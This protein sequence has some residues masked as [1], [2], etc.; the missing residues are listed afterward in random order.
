MQSAEAVLEV[1]RER[2]RRGLP[3][4]RVYRQ[5][6]NRD[7]YLRAYGRLARN[8]GAL[9]PGPTAETA[10]G[11]SVAKIDA[12]IEAV[13]FERYRWTPVRRTYLPKPNGKRR[14]LGIPTW[15]DKLLQEV[16]RSLLE[17]YY[18][19]QF[20]DHSHGFRPGRG[21]HTALTEVYRGWKGTTWFIEGDIAQCFDSLDHE[22]LLALLRERLHDHRFLR[23]VAGS[24]TAGYLEDWAFHATLSGAPQG[25]VVSPVLSNIYL[26]R[27]DRFVETTLLPAYNRG[28]RRRANPAYTQLNN[29]ASKARRNGDQ[30]AARELRR[31]MQRLPSVAA[32]DPAYR[33]LRY[34][35]YADDW[36]LGFVGPRREAEAI[37]T[38][39]R[40]FLSAT[41]KLQLS[42]A[43]TVITHARSHA[44]RFLGYEATV[45]HDDRKHDQTGGR[46]INGV[47]GLKVP[48]DVVRRNAAGYLRHGKPI[49]RTERVND[50]A[51][52][53]VARYQQEFRG[54]VE[55]YRLA[56]NLHRF[57]R[58]AWDM[59]RSLTKTLAHKLRVSVRQVLRRFR[60]T[61]ATPE[62]VKRVLLVTIPRDGAKPPLIAQWGGLSLAR[63][64]E[65]VLDDHPPRVWNARTELLTRLLATT[66][67]RCGSHTAVEVH[68]VRH[69]K[70][71]QRAGRSRR[72]AWVE[73]MAA[74]RRKT[75]VTCRPC[76]EAIH[77]GRPIAARRD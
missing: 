67:E 35:R 48:L 69:L 46:C 10:D 71:L 5:L 68:H 21:C 32:V 11:M 58:L 74:R 52:S 47:I 63:R 34:I 51:F 38:Q 23:L 66:C 64:K 56:Y 17:A 61:V 18:E 2:G 77:A 50:S 3:L 76:H 55:Y 73:L 8:R 20:S 53:I 16:I 49:H 1:I 13:R 12:L 27:L 4:E 14:P 33:R 41:L 36:L 24:L 15:S 9:T 57:T 6:F 70:D 59:E 62:G 65:A 75:L 31:Q 37:K 45:I 22:V 60:A 29:A 30:I 25:G 54:V 39:L 72:P 28:A 40:E 43:K 26:D 42:D 7:L 44:A 19:P